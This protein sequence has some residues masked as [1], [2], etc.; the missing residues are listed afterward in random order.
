MSQYY[1][2]QN[3]PAEELL[4]D[5]KRPRW[6]VEDFLESVDIELNMHDET[7]EK[8]SN[9]HPR[10]IPP[11]II[12]PR[13]IVV[14]G[15]IDAGKSTFCKHL[16]KYLIDEGF[17]AIIIEEAVADKDFGRDGGITLEEYYKNPKE[18]AFPFQ[19]Q[20]VHALGRQL[21]PCRFAEGYTCYHDLW[22]TFVP[23]DGCRWPRPTRE[24][25]GPHLQART[26][27]A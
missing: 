22:P 23:G 19:E 25:L 7:I 10:A 11:A 21:L 9:L 6:S 4:V 13:I 5:E 2:S 1:E 14:D 15:P 18:L 3:Q 17:N 16:R 20:V 8:L 26:P 12:D 24:I 27:A